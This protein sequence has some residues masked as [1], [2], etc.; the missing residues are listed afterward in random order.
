[1]LPKGTFQRCRPDPEEDKMPKGSLAPDMTLTKK[2]ETEKGEFALSLGSHS[3]NLEHSV[4]Q[5]SSSLLLEHH[6]LSWLGTGNS[7]RYMSGP[8]HIWVWLEKPPRARF[9]SSSFVGTVFCSLHL[10]VQCCT[11]NCT[12]GRLLEGTISH[13]QLIRKVPEANCTPE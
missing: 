2:S 13:G 12:N 4:T 1:M 6:F 9:P 5:G 8:W 7:R 3:H 10:W 11:I